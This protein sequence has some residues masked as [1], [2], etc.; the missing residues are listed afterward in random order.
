MT[1]EPAEHRLTGVAG[2]GPPLV[3][4]QESHLPTPG[5]GF[6]TAQ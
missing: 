1:P 5:L 3:Q 6:P 4:L 2:A